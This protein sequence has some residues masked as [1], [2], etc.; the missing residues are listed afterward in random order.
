VRP[1]RPGPLAK[2]GPLALKAKPVQQA[3]KAQQ[4]P[5]LDRLVLLVPSARPV[6][7]AALAKKARPARPARL[8]LLALTARPARPARPVQKAGKVKTALPGPKGQ[9]PVAAANRSA[10][11]TNS[12]NKNSNL[13][14][15]SK[16]AGVKRRSTPR[17][18]LSRGD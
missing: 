6:Q 2:K 10:K 9:V 3:L 11:P 5:L 4:A 7:K 13:D 8:A 17:R 1:A 12:V 15:R 14:R 18:Q 16:A